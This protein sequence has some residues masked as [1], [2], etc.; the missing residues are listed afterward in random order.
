MSQTL[1]APSGP[2]ESVSAVA[3]AGPSPLIDPR[4]E[5][6]VFWR[7]RRR[8]LRNTVRHTWQQSRLRVSLVVCM[9]TIFWI[10]LFLLFYDAFDFV[11]AAILHAGTRQQT[12]RVVFG[13]FFVSLLVMLVFSTAIML[14]GGLYR[15][16]EASFLLT[17]PAR[18]E[19][20]FSHKYLETMFFSSWGFVL[21]GSPMLLA[22][23]LVTGAP[24]YFYA[25][26]LPLL[27]A[28]VFVPGAVGAIAT[29]AIVAFL[30]RRR[31]LVL[32]VALA[33]AVN[34]IVL[35]LWWI[36]A[37]SHSP[38]L[39]ASWFKEVLGRLSFVEGRLLPSWWLTM[40]LLES[41]E[42]RWS[43]GVLFA[44]LL[45]S[46]ALFGQLL[47]A[48]VAT[49][50]YRA[51][52][53]RLQGYSSNSRRRGTSALDRWLARALFF[54][55][56]KMRLLLI[57]DVRIFRRDPMQWSQFLIFFGLLG[58]Y[59][60]NIRRF[61]YDAHHQT[62]INMI[63]FLNLAVVGLILSTFTNRFI[64]PM[65]SLEGRRFWVL[66]R[67]PVRRDTI[68]WSK[69]LFASVGSLVPC[70]ALILLSDTMLQIAPWIV[71]VHLMCCTV[72]CTGLAGIAVG[73]GAKMPNLREDSPTKIAAGF[74]GT[75][76]LV[77]STLYIVAIIL[78]SAVPCHFYLE[79]MQATGRATLASP[80]AI[81]R[82][83]YL[84]A[85]A[86]FLLGLVATFLPLW[87]GARAFRQM[88]F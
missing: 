3:A 55:S 85:A 24:W 86:S 25:M 81:L 76:N 14:Y 49:R 34:A 56:P 33:V 9:S 22:Y 68:L 42:G 44:A 61:S 63:S 23:G 69:F 72:L 47:A 48:W 29:M 58:L 15:S 60:L 53:H 88:E 27:V 36:G 39:T 52:Y 18:T 13:V 5:A 62:W 84:G 77:V 4:T 80:Q 40:G 12:V 6:A 20:I 43:E 74:G 28:F 19:R 54:V 31:G 32:A 37:A 79:A 73:M 41:A 64:F 87:I 2:F 70:A 10:G 67:L 46:N 65:I 17:T 66:G 51:G 57:K 38:L 78:M 75:L 50:I 7:L 45:I 30:P 1:A 59:F 35:G 11:H 21:L 8:L 82:W 16:Q 83:V 26:L 71:A